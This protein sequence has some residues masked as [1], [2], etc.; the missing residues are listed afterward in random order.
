MSEFPY[1]SG[2]A[3]LTGAASGIGEATAKGLAMRGMDM[4]IIDKDAEPLEA[5]ATGLRA[6]YPKLT[7]STHVVDLSEAAPIAALPE[8]VRRSHERVSMLIN[9]AGVALGGTFEDV[10]LAD[11]EFVMAVNF[12]AAVRMSKAFM[13]DLRAADSALM[14]NISS[15]FGLIGT[16]GQTAYTASKFAIRGFSESLRTEVS[17]FGIKVLQVHPGGIKTNVANNARLGANLTRG[18]VDQV[19]SSF[20]KVLTMDPRV[21]AEQILNAAAAGKNRLVITKEA[22]ALDLLARLLP[23]KHGEIIAKEMLRRTGVKL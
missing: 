9:N 8:E 21:A 15:L 19:R 4:A 14:I 3:V 13:P 5:L 20:N 6:N 12:W 17:R 22:K 23:A 10:S 16:P 18:D 7:I 1:V 2:A 11:I